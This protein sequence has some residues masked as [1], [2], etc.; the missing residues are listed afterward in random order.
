MKNQTN[1]AFTRL[2]LAGIATLG[3]LGSSASTVLA[4]TRTQEHSAHCKG[5]YVPLVRVAEGW[6]R[7]LSDEAFPQTDGAEGAAKQ[8]VDA[9]LGVPYAA[10]PVGELRFAPPQ[11]LPRWQGIRDATTVSTDCAQA[12]GTQST[13]DCL[14][15]NIYVP[16]HAGANLPVLFFLPGGGFMVGGA[17][18]FVGRELASQERVIV[19]TVNYRLN[20]FGFLR[21]PGAAEDSSLPQGNQ[22]LLDQQAALTWVQRNIAR[23]G[24]D[25]TRITMAGSSSGATSTCAHLA[26]PNVQ[27]SIFAGFIWSGACSAN[28]PEEMES[29]SAD[30]LIN[31][32][33]AEE[34]D[35]LGC[36]RSKSTEELIGALGAFQADIIS[37]TP[38]LPLHPMDAVA[39][40][41]FANAP[42]MVTETSDEARI[43]F[44]DLFPLPEDAY[45][46][47]L[48]AFVP[49]RGA[50]I[51]SE[52]PASEF[53]DPFYGFTQ[54]L[55][56]MAG[57]CLVRGE[58]AELSEVTTVFFGEFAD[59]N[60]P[61]PAWA[62]QPEGLVLGPTHTADTPYYF[63]RAGTVRPDAA[64][65]DDEQEHLRWEMRRALGALMRK[66]NPS[67]RHG[68]AWPA[69]S[70]ETDLAMLLE[71][72]SVHVISD[73]AT[74]HHCDFW[75][76]EP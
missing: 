36:L 5:D 41:S 55:S 25:P 4:R 21:L 24:G 10:P 19:V 28:A 44:T 20:A 70:P 11:A 48:D 61:A 59:P 23:F 57:N 45:V 58:V 62:P 15:L 7:G 29:R 34:A 8:P 50:A 9:F 31:A 75:S 73:H 46:S 14:Q 22:G 51:A 64:P 6:L 2:V 35:V 12:G 74:R 13:E 40:G 33:C 53:E 26:S 56:D 52:Y 18:G 71:P 66:G 16:R 42:L 17:S 30:L 3:A 38:E 76:Q 47:L 72:G 37:G 43:F 63:D 65:F 49:G 54:M 68:T 60:A 1:T 32:G 27:D 39:A 67:P 69:Y